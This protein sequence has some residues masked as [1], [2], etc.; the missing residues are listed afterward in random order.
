VA[1][2]ALVKVTRFEANAAAAPQQPKARPAEFSEE[3]LTVFDDQG[4]EARGRSIAVR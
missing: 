2:A 3:H 4:G 1:V